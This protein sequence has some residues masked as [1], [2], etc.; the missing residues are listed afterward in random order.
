[1]KTIT[2][3]LALC[4]AILTIA[5]TAPATAEQRLSPGIWTNTEDAYFAAEEGR[6]PPDEM[7]FEIA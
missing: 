7:A 2:H 1:M 3:Y 5:T 6:G 4:A